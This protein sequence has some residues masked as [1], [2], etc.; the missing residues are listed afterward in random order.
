MEIY[1]VR[2]MDIDEEK[3]DKICLLI[4]PEKKNKIERFI[5]RKDKIRT[6]IGHILIKTIII[7]KLNI[8]SKNIVFGEND[9]GKPYLKNYPEFCFNISHSGGFVACA[10]DSY[11]IGID[12]EQIRHINYEELSKEFF[13]ESEFSYINNNEN[14]NDALKRFFEIWT[15]KESY[16]KCRGKGVSIP[17]NLFSINI[18]KDDS[19]R[20]M[21]SNQ[22]EEYNF[23]R[24][25]V[26]ENYKMA[27]C[28]LNDKIPTSILEVDQDNIINN[29][30]RIY[31]NIRYR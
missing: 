26:N 5:N 25:D 8:E 29:Y 15:L 2:I 21:V 31:S 24:F 19:I 7:K 11:P 20:V 28:S 6:V 9:Y 12:I 4:E 22:Y 16:I 30:F 3:F 23:K 14:H 27:V 18:G 17:L 13:S 10:I 1:V